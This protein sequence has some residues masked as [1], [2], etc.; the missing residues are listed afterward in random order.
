M[1]KSKRIRSDR[2]RLM[3]ES[4]DKFEKVNSAKKARTTTIVL[5]SVMLALVL[6]FGTLIVLDRTGIILRS[7][8]V[9]ES[10][11]YQINGIMVNYLYNSAYSSY[12]SSYGEYTSY[13]INE[14]YITSQCKQILSLC[15]AARAEGYEITELDRKN[16]ENSIKTIEESVK[17]SGYSLSAL[18]G[19]GVTMGDIRAALE[20]QTLAS[21]YS[22][23]KSD[24]LENGYIANPDKIDEYFENNKTS[25]LEG[26]YISA[27]TSNAEWRE[28]LAAAKTAEEFKTIFIELY[29][30]ENFVKKYQEKETEG[31]EK[32]AVSLLE[33]LSK[34]AKDAIGFVLYDIEVKGSDDKALKLDEEA[35]TVTEAMIKT[36]YE[37]K[38]KASYAAADGETGITEITDAIYKAAATAA[39]TLRTSI[40][41][42][43][44]EDTAHTYPNKTEVSRDDYNT[45]AGT[46]AEGETTAENT[47]AANTTTAAGTTAAG[48]T[49]AVDNTPAEPDK[50][51]AF[52]TWF[53]SGDREEKDVFTEDANKIYF[54]IEP[55]KK[56]TDKTVNVGHI[57]ISAPAHDHDDDEE[58]DA[59]HKA[60]EEKTDAEAKAKAESILAEF[61]AGTMSKETFEALAMKYTEDSGIFYDNVLPDAMV[62]EFNDWIYD[63]ARVVGDVAVVKTEYGYHVMYFLG[64]GIENWQAEV[65]ELMVDEE[66]TT[67]T[68]QLEKDY[69]VSVSEAGLKKIFG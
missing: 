17:E 11:N 49:T 54:V 60:E 48:T 66:M 19:K 34:A 27:V 31:A 20:L 18:Y 2:A 36:I 57:L 35:K 15:E 51:N 55:A 64:D 22:T 42:N 53:F 10:D 7:N 21:S 28:K 41:G 23:N 12:Y 16:L 5:I 47:T 63:E 50:L 44:T 45:T 4:P 29:T 39:D 68:K 52:D 59:D 37:A 13:I 24:S 25:L 9:F 3:V 8:I 26:G 14:S 33:N 32:V 40:S 1:G 46:T 69:P 67:W 6:V 30:S 56:N 62:E 58:V 38:Y 61:K 43:I 65:V